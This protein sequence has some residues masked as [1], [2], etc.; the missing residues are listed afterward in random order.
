MSDD[1][2]NGKKED[3]DIISGWVQRVRSIKSLMVY[4]QR[5]LAQHR[6]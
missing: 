2:Q 5:S 6:F 1:G 3:I 4:D